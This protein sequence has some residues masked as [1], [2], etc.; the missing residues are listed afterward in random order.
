MSD[1]QPGRRDRVNSK[2]ALRDMILAT[3]EALLESKRLAKLAELELRS[4]TK[5]KKKSSSKSTSP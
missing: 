1:I 3:R 5:A 4:Q 2:R